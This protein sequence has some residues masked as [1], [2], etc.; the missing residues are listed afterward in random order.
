MLR[1]LDSTVMNFGMTARMHSVP[2]ELRG[3]MP[4]PIRE[5]AMQASKVSF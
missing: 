1:V 3:Q 5:T 2:I 4:I